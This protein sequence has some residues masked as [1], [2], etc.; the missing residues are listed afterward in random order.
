MVQKNLGPSIAEQ[1]AVIEDW[2]KQLAEKEF[3]MSLRQGRNL[4]S[5]ASHVRAV[6][7][8]LVTQHLIKKGI[9]SDDYNASMLYREEYTEDDPAHQGEAESKHKSL[10]YEEFMSI[11]SKRMFRDALLRVTDRIDKIVSINDNNKDG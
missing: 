2:W 7:T 4:V 11:F 5:H 10:T 1:N 9:V 6:D 3:E 8:N